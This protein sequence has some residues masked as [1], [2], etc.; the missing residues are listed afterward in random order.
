V[1]VA[2]SLVIL[3]SIIECAADRVLNG[4]MMLDR[5]DAKEAKKRW[6]M[7]IDGEERKVVS[8][9]TRGIYTLFTF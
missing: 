9:W 4:A 1:I 5:K 6:V 8:Q 3:I 7:C 2:I